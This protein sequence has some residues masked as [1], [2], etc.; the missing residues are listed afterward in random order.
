M[1]CRTR[2]GYKGYAE[3]YSSGSDGVSRLCEAAYWTRLRYDFHYFW[4]STRS[5]IA[6]EA[7]DRIGRRYDVERTINRQP[8]EVR[9]AARPD[10]LGKG[11]GFLELV[12]AVTPTH[13]GR[14]RPCQ[15]VLLWP[16]S[17]GSLQ[18]VPD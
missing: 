5:D 17:V 4:T 11:Y 15:G 7:L 6:S 12:R 13:S 14:E 2:D 3:L 8:A 9:H 10:E 16:Q 18:P 1:S